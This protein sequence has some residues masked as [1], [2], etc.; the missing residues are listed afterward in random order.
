MRNTLL[1]AAGF[2]IA[3]AASGQVLYELGPDIGDIESGVSVSVDLDLLA[4]DPNWIGFPT[5]EEGM[6]IAVQSGFEETDGNYVWKGRTPG[7]QTNSTLIVGDESGFFGT[8]GEYGSQ[9]YEVVG[10]AEGVRV[11]PIV[12]T[13]IPDNMLKYKLLPPNQPD[14]DSYHDEDLVGVSSASTDTNAVIDV[15]VFYTEAAR[16]Y[17][18]TW[19]TWDPNVGL[20][21][22]NGMLSYPIQ[23]INEVLANGTIPASLRMV[24]YQ[25]M[26]STVPT[27]P[28]GGKDWLDVL[29]DDKNLRKLR[30]DH[31]ADIVIAY[32]HEPSPTPCGH[33]YIRDATFE[34]GN[35]NR[36]FRR[37]AI[38]MVNVYCDDVNWT[39]WWMTAAHEIGHF[40]GA[41]HDP[42][43]AIK[44]PD[45]IMAPYAYAYID[46]PNSKRT[47]MAYGF[48][49]DQVPYYSTARVSP[50][51][52]TLGKTGTAENE[53]VMKA[54]VAKTATYSDIPDR[55]INVTAE[56]SRKG[57]ATIRWTDTA[58]NETSFRVYYRRLGAGKKWK[59]WRLSL[60]RPNLGS[61]DIPGLKIGK[62]YR[63]YVKAWN[64]NHQ[65]LSS[66]KVQVRIK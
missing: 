10:S 64:G 50:N 59:E 5:V 2:L 49:Y 25:K 14:P 31:K 62:Q 43:N 55:P 56:A 18:H 15:M 11:R 60:G 36:R 45:R 66:E 51:G 28:P 44:D 17:W 58:D 39:R 20:T 12:R 53:K 48:S 41:M 29:V 26:P 9:R 7:S 61:T 1:V 40:H 19:Y 24:H 32:I 13:P 52:W 37:Y 65:S 30:R 35:G 54:M 38:A 47:A 34:T 3:T 33:A 6:I 21:G 22:T 23:Y 16:R 4:S 8:F 46:R 63:F 27:K 42:A 57:T